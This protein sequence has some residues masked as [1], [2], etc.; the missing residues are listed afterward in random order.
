MMTST[1]E[2]PKRKEGAKLQQETILA[3][4]FQTSPDK[5]HTS[6][7]H[8]DELFAGPE[9]P[10]K[11][12]RDEQPELGTLYQAKSN[13]ENLENI[14]HLLPCGVILLN[15][16]GVVFDCNK[17]AEDLLGASIKN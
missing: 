14:L 9:Y 11:V 15:G 3:S 13:T 17:A 5:S 6:L 16:R 2:S 8:F 7:K 12:L 1:I 10:S 4:A